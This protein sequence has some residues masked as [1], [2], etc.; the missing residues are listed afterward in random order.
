[1]A[2]IDSALTE[3]TEGTGVQPFRKEDLSS[4]E[5]VAQQ[6]SQRAPDARG[7]GDRNNWRYYGDNVDPLSLFVGAAAWNVL[8]AS[9]AMGATED[10]LESPLPTPEPN[11]SE[12]SSGELPEASGALQDSAIRSA[13]ANVGAGPGASASPLPGRFEKVD[14]AVPLALDGRS[15]EAPLSS[16]ASGGT[17][18]TPM[19]GAGLRSNGAMP[20]DQEEAGHLDLPEVPGSAAPPAGGWSRVGETLQGAVQVNLSISDH[21]SVAY[22]TAFTHIE[23]IHDSVVFIE[24]NVATA[25]ATNTAPVWQMNAQT[26][27]NSDIP[28]SSDLQNLAVTDNDAISFAYSGTFIDYAQNSIIVIIGNNSSSSAANES[29]VLQSIQ[30]SWGFDDADDASF[31]MVHEKNF[32]ATENDS[33]A[34]NAAAV[35]IEQNV[36][37]TAF[38][39]PDLDGALTALK[40]DA[41]EHPMWDPFAEH[42]FAMADHTA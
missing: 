8:P 21:D 14:V 32:A 9:T 5:T 3:A 15:G 37:S 41:S 34:V 16:Q 22:A 10:P 42:S 39:V 26:G 29:P 7:D 24:G 30:T 20:G 4:G 2:T 18:G 25:I 17:G 28:G 1:M 31:G 40:G 23:S 19:V 27:G 11:R 36:D 12:R 33:V 38:V 13:P 6:Q 35:V